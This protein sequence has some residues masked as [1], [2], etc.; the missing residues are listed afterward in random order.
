VA[1]S[2][3]LTGLVDTSVVIHAGGLPTGVEGTFAVSVM[4]IAELHKGAVMARS[5]RIRAQRI[6]RLA[7]AEQLFEALPVDRRVAVRFGEI[8]AATRRL[9]R[10]PHAVDGLIA[11][12]A[13]VHGL[14]V[15]TFDDDFDRIPGLD[16]VK[17]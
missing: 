4:T 1:A 12:T 6:A 11:A 15:Y 17:L 16:V 9:D 10:S 2:R 8:A 5:E 3:A 14:P 7:L 13:M